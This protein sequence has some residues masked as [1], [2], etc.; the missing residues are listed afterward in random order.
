VDAH[1]AALMFIGSAV[2]LNIGILLRGNEMRCCL[3]IGCAT[4][5]LSET[6]RLPKLGGLQDL[7]AVPAAVLTP[8]STVLKCMVIK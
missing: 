4:Y 7:F 2:L 8:L 1:I 3:L 6:A 5:L